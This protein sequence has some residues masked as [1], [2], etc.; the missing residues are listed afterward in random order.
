MSHGKATHPP[1]G[2]T[3]QKAE[4]GG[5]TAEVKPRSPRAKLSEEELEA[6]MR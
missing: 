1:D 2:T 5:A 3:K 6:C 4:V